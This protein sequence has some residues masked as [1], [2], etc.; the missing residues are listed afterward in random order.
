M[1]LGRRHDCSCIE[2]QEDG[3]K[4]FLW[5]AAI[6]ICRYLHPYNPRLA[7]DLIFQLRDR[8]YPTHKGEFGSIVPYI[9]NLTEA[10]NVPIPDELIQQTREVLRK[11]MEHERERPA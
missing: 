6:R 11:V 9:G 2:V 3:M 4:W 7:H 10:N 1:A 5:K 8:W